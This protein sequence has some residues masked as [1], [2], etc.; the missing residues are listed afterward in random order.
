Y[1][2]RNATQLG[3]EFEGLFRANQSAW[4]FFQAQPSWYRKTAIWWV[5]SAK[6]DETRRKRLATLIDDSAHARTI[7]QLTRPPKAPSV[8]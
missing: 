5:V 7:R 8:E 3:D 1:E 6:K 4:D 2:Q